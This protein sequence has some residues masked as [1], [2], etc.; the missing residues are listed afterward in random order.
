MGLCRQKQIAPLRVCNGSGIRAGYVSARELALRRGRLRKAPAP[1][2]AVQRHPARAGV[3]LREARTVETQP[4]PRRERKLALE[5]RNQRLL[6][7]PQAAFFLQSRGSAR[8]FCVP[9]PIV[10]PHGVRYA[11][12]DHQ[13]NLVVQ[14]KLTAHA[15]LDQLVVVVSHPEEVDGGNG[16]GKNLVLPA[17]VAI[18][19]GRELVAIRGANEQRRPVDARGDHE[20]RLYISLHVVGAVTLFLRRRF[21]SFLLFYLAPL[22]AG[23]VRF[24]LFAFSLP[25]PASGQCGVPPLQIAEVVERVHA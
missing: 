3:A 25:L 6:D 18:L 22:C 13:P 20:V 7:Q 14:E 19:Q 9:R 12:A 8:L 4:L 17:A 15:N 24:P 21:R 11:C 10:Q 16:P 1:L 23:V 5:R 2:L